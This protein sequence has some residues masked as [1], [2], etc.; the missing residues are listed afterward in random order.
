MLIH[1][2]IKKKIIK[3]ATHGVGRRLRQ[4]RIWEW[5]VVLV[6]TLAALG[7]WTKKCR[8]SEGAHGA[9]DGGRG[10]FMCS[11]QFVVMLHTISQQG[12]VTV[13]SFAQFEFIVD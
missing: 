7:P 3:N 12:T 8:E 1:D 9:E 11:K 5:W 13:R 6:H 2:W 4:I 10:P